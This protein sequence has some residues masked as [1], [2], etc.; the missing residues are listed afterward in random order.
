MAFSALTHK[1]WTDLSRRRARTVFAVSTLAIAVASVGIFAV[2]PLM[3]RAMNREV[4]ASRLYDLQLSMPPVKLS[5]ADVQAIGALP[6]VRAVVARPWFATR[7]YVGTQRVKALVVGAPDLNRQ[8]VDRVTVTSGGL[9]AGASVLTD[10]QNARQ[11]VWGGTAGDSLRIVS[12]SGRIHRVRVTGEAR[13][14]IASDAVAGGLLVVYASPATVAHLTGG[15]EVGMMELRLRNISPAAAATTVAEVRSYLRAHTSFTSFSNLPAVRAEG[16]YP[17]KEFFGQLGQ[18]L[19]VITL[20]ALVSGLFLIGN[21]MS[22]LVSEQTTEI[23]MMKAIGGS[24]RRI[25]VAYIRT[26]LLLGLM[27]TLIGVPL[28]ILLSNFLASYF[29]QTWYAIS[30]GFGV[31]VPVVVAAVVVGLVGPV[32]ASM[33]AIRKATA[34]PVVQALTV[35]GIAAGS[36][37][38]FDRALRTL[39]LPKNVEIGVRSMG[40]RKRRT[41]GTTML[42]ALGVA[43]LLALVALG[44]SVTNTSHAAFDA[45]GYDI[46]LGANSGSGGGR[47]LDATAQR[48]VTQTPGVAAAQ[49]FVQSL[50]KL[51]GQDED[52]MGI[53]PNGMIQPGASQGRWLRGADQKQGDAVA[54]IGADVAR[55]TGAQLGDRIRVETGAGPAIFRVIGVSASPGAIQH[56]Y[57]PLRAAQHALGLRGKADGY[58]I[59]STSPAH[60][61]IDR[62]T[63]RLED[64]LA[65]HGYSVSGSER[66]VDERQNVASNA[67]ITNAITA[68]G[69]IIVAISMIGLVNTMTANVLER[70]REIGILRCIG[71]HRRDIRRIFESEGLA[72]SV[73]GWLAG[74]PLGYLTFRLFLKAVSNIMNL[75]LVGT[76]PVMNILIALVGTVVLAMIMMILPLR[77]AIRFHPGDALRYQ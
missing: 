13:S 67:K 15:P 32:L 44:L 61:A 43:N 1:S 74:I 77:R 9:T 6:N 63:I 50:V 54:V 29:A 65:A 57:V 68:L 19:S 66:Y 3:D 11:G 40:R 47:P 48:L 59:R 45:L 75:D 26:A 27:G 34:V 30:P 36:T 52:F 71:A 33:P 38:A 31:V 4:R 7:A 42:V 53:V 51:H 35:G 64:R 18:L 25:G 62:T 73:L 8:P 22:T 69:F 20:L 41:L 56:I 17:G 46:A 60:A 76:F 10:I 21:T 14:M 39:R 70:T 12:T 23:G 49:P 16:D 37:G 55:A 5:S 28:G 24:R 2:S 72:V 58:L